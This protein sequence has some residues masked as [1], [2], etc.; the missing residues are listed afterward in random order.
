MFCIR[1]SF[2]PIGT[3]PENAQTSQMTPDLWVSQHSKT[4]IACRSGAAL[5][6][7]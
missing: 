3:M 1:N 6:L 7:A 4:I 2:V 5:D